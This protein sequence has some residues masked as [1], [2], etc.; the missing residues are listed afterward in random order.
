MHFKLKVV[1]GALKSPNGRNVGTEITVPVRRF[2]I[3]TARDCQMRC[4]GQSIGPHHCVILVEGDRVVVRDGGTHTGTFVNGVRVATAACLFHGDRL[5]VGKLEFDVLMPVDTPR[6]EPTPP[7]VALPLSQRDTVVDANDT[8]AE[9][10][11]DLLINADEAERE[12]RRFDPASREFQPANEGAVSPA[13]L[14][15]ETTSHPRVP[16]KRPPATLPA[17]P[18]LRGQDTIDAAQQALSRLLTP[19]NK[20]KSS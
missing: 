9:M 16:V 17:P 6:G 7:P 11:V 3:G 20:K 18:P 13:E 19:P 14:A 4:S 2:V 5:Q 12:R 10:V 8:V 15:D 1:Q